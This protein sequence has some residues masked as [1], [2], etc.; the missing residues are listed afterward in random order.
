[1]TNPLRILSLL[2]ASLALSGCAGSFLSAAGPSIRQIQQQADTAQ[3]DAALP[4]QLVDLSA[5]TIAPYMR[6]PEPVPM[7]DVTAKQVPQLRLAPGDVVRLMVADTEVDGGIFAPLSTGG[8]VFEHLR[9]EADGRI[10]LPYAGHI[11]V[12]GLTPYEVEQLIRRKLKGVSADPQVH[13]ALMGDQSS[14]VLVAGAV[15]KPGRVSTLDGPLTLLDA[16]NQ[17]G[18]A[19]LEPYL[20]R[21]TLRTGNEAQVF[22]YQDVLQ[23]QNRI[24]PP[25][26]EVILDRNRQRF[27]AMG[28]VVKPGLHDFPAPNPSLLEALGA[29]GGLRDSTSDAT[30][31]FVFRLTDPASTDPAAAP[32]KPIAQVFRLNMEDPSALFLARQFLV[33]PED[34]I[35]VTNA[36]VYEWQKII[37]PIVQVLVLGRTAD[38]LGR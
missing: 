21:V 27:V 29:V 38:A 5:A 1:M 28:A 36:G 8:T 25:D 12:A 6:P 10:S 11:R 17:A 34:A 3:A 18:G 30:G 23:G 26:S 15:K 19:V 35:Y 9:V 31:V 14:S 24:I 22:N 2:A 33:Q 7:P 4:Y 16:I 20:V 37:S 32:G 13:V